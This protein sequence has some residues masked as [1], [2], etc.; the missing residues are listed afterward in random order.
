VKDIVNVCVGPELQTVGGLPD[1]PHRL[2][3]VGIAWPQLNVL[4]RYEQHRLPV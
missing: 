3:R 2:E 1:G 4:A